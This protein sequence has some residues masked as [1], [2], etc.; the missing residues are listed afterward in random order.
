M[1]LDLVTPADISE[2]SSIWHKHHRE[3]YSLPDRRNLI[4]EA[5]AVED[6]KIIAYGQV[7]HIAEPIFVLDLNARMRL[8]LEALDMLMQEAYRGTS[9]AGLSKMFAF[10]RDEHFSKVI[11][12]RYAFEPSDLGRF[13]LKEL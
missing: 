6:G 9:R 13:M 4:V 12:K 5:K 3:Q 11:A 1:K 8:K 7:R 2:I 10:I